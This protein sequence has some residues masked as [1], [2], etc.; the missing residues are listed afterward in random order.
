[1]SMHLTPFLSDT[2]GILLFFVLLSLAIKVQLCTLQYPIKYGSA[3]SF[4]SAC[5]RAFRK[6]VLYS[7]LIIGIAALKLA[8]SVST[9]KCF[10]HFFTHFLKSP[11]DLRN[12]LFPILQSQWF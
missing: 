12:H 3:S 11:V 10:S 9:T 4:P 2:A 8:A 6:P 7:E 1:M 5:F